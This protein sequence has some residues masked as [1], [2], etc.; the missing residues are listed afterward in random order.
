MRALGIRSYGVTCTRVL[1]QTYMYLF[2]SM[3][4]YTNT[5]TK[6][7]W[8]IW[9]QYVQC[10]N[11]CMHVAFRRWTRYQCY[12]VGPPVINGQTPL[13]HLFVRPISGECI[14][15]EMCAYAV[16]KPQRIKTL[17]LASFCCGCWV[18]FFRHARARWD[19]F[20]WFKH[21]GLTGA[22]VWREYF[23]LASQNKRCVCRMR[24]LHET[25]D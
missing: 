25:K 9:M 4:G 7:A 6:R 12:Y 10:Y 5:G 13:S 17:Y 22:T 14:F 2:R 18:K 23:I 1:R 16:R 3:Y 24:F 20:I 19:I 11:T 21:S 15:R 8:Q